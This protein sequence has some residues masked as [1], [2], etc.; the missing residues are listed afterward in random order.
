MTSIN[1]SIRQS[2]FKETSVLHLYLMMKLTAFW[3]AEN[4][5]FAHPNKCQYI[6]YSKACWI[7]LGSFRSLLRN[8]CKRH[9]F[10][11]GI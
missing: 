11:N 2:V 8:I 3:C 9:N 7:F 1:I 4:A 5:I 6:F 10:K